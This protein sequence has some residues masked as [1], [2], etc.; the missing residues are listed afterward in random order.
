MPTNDYFIT[1]NSRPELLEPEI[2]SALGSEP[3]NALGS[4]LE[5]YNSFYLYI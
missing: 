1:K 3:F 4:N 2:K 5:L